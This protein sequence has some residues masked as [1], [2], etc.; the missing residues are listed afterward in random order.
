MTGVNCCFPFYRA[1][2][3]SGWPARD[4]RSSVGMKALEKLTMLGWEMKRHSGSGTTATL[5]WG[6]ATE[7]SS[8]RRAVG[9]WVSTL[10]QPSLEKWNGTWKISNGH[11]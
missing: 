8:R 1:I 7:G 5:C 3:Q 4:R 6:W 10:D 11:F 9:K 2:C